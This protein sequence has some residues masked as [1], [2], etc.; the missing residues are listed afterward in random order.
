[1]CASIYTEF[2]IRFTFLERPKIDDKFKITFRNYLINTKD[3]QILSH[4]PIKTEYISYLDG[5][6]MVHV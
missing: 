6:S 3:R 2:K 5:V 4:N 1:M